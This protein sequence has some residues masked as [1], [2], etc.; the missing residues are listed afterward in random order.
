VG[1][2]IP[3][4]AAEETLCFVYEPRPSTGRRGDVEIW[5]L[6]AFTA[7]TPGAQALLSDRAA[8]SGL[9]ESV[10]AGHSTDPRE[11]IPAA[12]PWRAQNR[13]V[14]SR[15]LGLLAVVLALV[16]MPAVA[17][18]GGG[19]EENASEQCEPLA[20]EATQSA[21]SCRAGA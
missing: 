12:F 8:R 16:T 4:H 19:D 17:G 10:A 18:R 7:P 2:T 3:S 1:K 15:R 13:D 5:R 20:A 21:H 14:A 6:S 9:S 11:K